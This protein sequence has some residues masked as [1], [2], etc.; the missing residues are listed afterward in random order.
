MWS[1]ASL[2]GRY[3]LEAPQFSLRTKIWFLDLCPVTTLCPARKR[4][5]TE[6][7]TLQHVS[8]ATQFWNIVHVT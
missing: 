5:K 7:T 6:L 2:S 8:N 1:A 4:P 3:Q